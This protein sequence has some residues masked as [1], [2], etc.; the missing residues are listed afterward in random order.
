MQ[1]I[2]LDHNAVQLKGAEQGV[3]GNSLVGSPISK[4]LWTITT[5]SSLA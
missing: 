1:D 5:T 3:E 2:G 4:E